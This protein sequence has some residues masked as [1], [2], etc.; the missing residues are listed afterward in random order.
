M[1]LS[2]TEALARLGS[3]PQSLYASVS[4]GRIRAKPD[5]AD[6][7]RS[8]YREEDVDRLAARARGRRSS[9]TVASEAI[10]W[11]D[12]VL[13]SAISTVSGGRLYYRGVDAIELATTATLEDVATLLWDGPWSLPAS[14]PGPVAATPMAAAFAALA[15][16]AVLGVPSSGLGPW[17]LRGE[18]AGVLGCVADAMLGA[19]AGP[20]HV[21]LADSLGRPRAAEVLRR[22]M[23]LLADHELN[24]STF[25]ARVAVSTGASLPAGALAGLATFTG[26][27]HGTAAAAVLAL[28]L[29]IGPHADRPGDGLREWLGEGRVIPGFGH[30][31]YPR[32]DLRAEALL[33]AIEVPASFRRLAL[34]AEALLGDRPNVDYALAA[35][36]AAYDLPPHAPATIFAL[37]RTVGWLAHMLEQVASGQLI[38]PRARYVGPAVEAT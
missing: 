33:A 25:A 9:A 3:K 7:R 23:V 28:A 21:R 35:V 14:A 10:S 4:R 31:L 38:R 11:G 6:T 8:L 34:T 36:S 12:P 22:T 19:G 20:L 37:A 18:A 17:Q 16:R 24:P 13:P 32:G 2:A 29:D 30:R 5:P 26:P 1:W 27:R 15:E